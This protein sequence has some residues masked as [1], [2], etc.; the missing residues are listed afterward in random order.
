MH[1]ILGATGHIGSAL[2][3]LLLTQAQP[4][5]LVLHTAKHE[6]EW[7]Q[8]GART[9]VADVH[10]T[11]T[12][13]RIF[14][15]GQ[16]LF[17]LN[18]PAAPTTDTA[19]EERK[20]AASIVAALEGSGLKKI[21]AESTYGAQP[22]NQVGD[23]GVL[24]ELEQA[25]AAQPIPASIIR[26]AY[27]FSNWDSALATAQQDGNIMSLFPADFKLPMVAPADIARLAARLLT[28]PLNHTGLHYIE[29]PARY[30]AA[31]VAAA[32]ADALHRPVTV[33]AV[34]RPQWPAALQQLG[35]SKPAAA[36]MAAMTGITLDE[37]YPQPEHPVR[38]ITTLHQ[39][40]SDLAQAAK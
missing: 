9:V 15:T 38:G 29:G 17:L 18:P 11:D 3:Q 31:D 16:R 28:E 23:L 21:V 26:A 2:A 33:E 36:S 27:Y 24:Y 4:V 10:D 39:Y 6:K 32:F 1:I 19:A 35:F 20:S 8:R 30:S 34:P 5:T 12:L 22:G 13:R 7:Q 25:L 14:Q 37:S 40:I